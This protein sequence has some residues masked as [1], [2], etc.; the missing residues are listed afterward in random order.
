MLNSITR[1]LVRLLDPFGTQRELKRIA[2]RLEQVDQQLKQQHKWRSHMLGKID[3]LVRANYLDPFLGE[4]YPFAI[5]ARRFQLYSQNEEDGIVLALLAAAGITGRTFVEIGSGASGG[6]SGLLAREFGWRG[7]MVDYAADKVE[8]ARVRYGLNPLVSF[9][10]LEVRPDNI[11]DLITRHGLAGE[12]DF[13]SLDIDSKDYWVFQA[14][15]ACSPRVLVLEYNAH[16]GPDAS[17]TIAADTDMAKATKGVHGASLAALT[18]LAGEK[19]YRLVACDPTGT[20]AFYLRD[21]LGPDIPAVRVELAY[22]PMR[23]RGDPL[24]QALRKPIDLP[25]A[26]AAA[27]ITLVEV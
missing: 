22:Q 13:F 24:G 25:A 7:V 9:E 16:F 11:D 18:K 8:K 10:A 26:A 2:E 20:N 19:G 23:D 17:L 21:D 4:A 14:M 15:T 12:V 27:G 3:A 5:T 1:R 6:N